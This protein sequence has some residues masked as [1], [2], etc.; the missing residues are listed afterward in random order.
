MIPSLKPP[1]PKDPPKQEREEGRIPQAT[2][3]HSNYPQKEVIQ[4]KS[5]IFE[6]L[7]IT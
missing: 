6:G 4:I 3:L 5:A 1:E 2:P 7:E